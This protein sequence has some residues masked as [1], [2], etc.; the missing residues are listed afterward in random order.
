MALMAA[1]YII[2]IA[3]GSG[4]GKTTF[5]KKILDQ[6]PTDKRCLIQL[7][8]YYLSQQPPENHLDGRPNYD[9]PEAFDWPLFLAHLQQLRAGHAVRSP[10]YDFERSRRYTDRTVEVGQGGVLII[11]GILTLWEERVRDLLDL[12][13]YLKVEAD[14]RFIRRLYR[15]V[16]ERG[17]KLDDII[18]QYYRSVRPMHLK[19]TQA[20]QLHADMIVGEHHD[21]AAAVIA[22][23][24]LRH[25]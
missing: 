10:L 2:G 15:D 14:I 12:K 20:T 23:E 6:L 21:R 4:S 16:A 9:A 8:N 25:L 1:L 7:D 18:E 11:E 5:A 13:I 3:G 19:Y 22:Q 24:A 17:R